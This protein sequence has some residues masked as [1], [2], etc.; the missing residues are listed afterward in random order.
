MKSIIKICD[1]KSAKDISN[2][3]NAIASNEGVIA[4]EVS[5]EKKEAQIQEVMD[6]TMIADM[7]ERLI[8]NL[9]KGYKQRVGLPRQFLDT[10]R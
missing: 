8:R 2:I 10:R 1:M 3:Q 4:C 5:L 6:M 9:S 7:A